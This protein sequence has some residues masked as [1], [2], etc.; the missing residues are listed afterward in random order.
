MSAA[1]F[2]ADLTLL[3]ASAGSAF[4]AFRARHTQ[5]RER[6]LLATWSVSCAFI[7]AAVLLQ[8]P[9]SPLPGDGALLQRMAVNL[10]LYAALPLLATALL[11]LSRHWF[12]S[13]AGWGRLLLALIALFELNRRLNLGAGYTQWLCIACLVAFAAASLWLRPSRAQQLALTGS[14]SLAATLVLTSPGALWWGP[15]P[16]SFR[17]LLALDLILLTTAVRATLIPA[18]MKAAQ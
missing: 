15:E 12:W 3:V 9:P 16:L 4:W 6:T 5:S 14:V 17:L 11:A 13:A 2:V 7:A 1:L 10:A 8:L 18:T